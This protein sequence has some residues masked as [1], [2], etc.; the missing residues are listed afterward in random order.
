MA[1]PTAQ[2]AADLAYLES[3]GVTHLRIAHSHY[4]DA[5]GVAN[6]RQLALEAKSMGF[7]VSHGL[8]APAPLS[9]TT[10]EGAYQTAVDAEAV[11]A[12]ANDI[13]EFMVGNELE[14]KADG[15]TLTDP[16]CRDWV[17][18][19]A[20]AIKAAGYTGIVSYAVAQGFSTNSAGWIADDDLGDLDLLGLNVYGDNVTNSNDGFEYYVNQAVG[21][22]GD[23]VYI[24]EF[25]VFYDWEQVLS[26]YSEA[27]VATE[28]E[29]RT[30]FLDSVGLARA[31]LFTW[32]FTDDEYAA[33]QE[34]GDV[35][36]MFAAYMGALA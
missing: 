21:A 14:D 10:L 33:K 23:Q 31:M 34:D 5:T 7:Y 29:A 30:Q 35:H 27:Q 28:V 8:A 17:R 24:S 20:T 9:D 32:R 3:Q 13:D 19:R 15:T 16:E 26:T 6:M 1:Y 36:P 4:S 11:W 25:N 12:Q 2:V 18:A 22:F